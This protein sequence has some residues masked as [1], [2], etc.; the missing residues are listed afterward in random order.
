M[1]NEVQ[2]PD[3]LELSPVG[4]AQDVTRMSKK[5]LYL[6]FIVAFLLLGVLVYSVNFAHNP[7]EEDYS[8]TVHIEENEKPLL[9]GEGSGLSLAPPPEAVAIPEPI[10]ATPERKEPLV[11]IPRDAEAVDYDAENMRRMKSQS[12]WSALSS[13]IIALRGSE[14]A[15]GQVDQQAMLELLA[16]GQQGGQPGAAGSEFGNQD[17]YNPA[18]DVDKENFAKRAGNDG[19]WINK[20]SRV[21]GNP[22]ELKTGSVIPGIMLTSVNSDLPGNIIAQVSQNVFDTATGRHLLIPQGSKLYGVYDS[23]VVYGQS[24]VLS[25]WTRI[26][27]PDGSSYTLEATPGTDMSGS[28]GFEDQVDN[29]YARIFGSAGIMALIVGGSAYAMDMA[30]PDGDNVSFQGEMISAL[31]AQFGQTTATLLEKNL[32]IK[33]TLEVRPGYQFN[34]V[35]IKDLV[36]EEPYT[37]WRQ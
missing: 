25:A 11:V 14:Q 36:L 22:Y 19:D 21:P 37:A 20:Y 29:H 33:P 31:A 7:E 13:P 3:K 10:V 18:A 4:K 27:F 12:Y 34:L 24:R 35:L 23:R 9:F 1:T 32:N 28:G 8:N 16:K 5:P 15:Q 17:S 30:A 6:V 2:S 26:I